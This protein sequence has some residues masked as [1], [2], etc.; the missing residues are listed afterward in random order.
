[1]KAKTCMMDLH[2]MNTKN[3]RRKL[4]NKKLTVNNVYIHAYASTDIFFCSDFSQTHLA[5]V[6]IFKT[7][8]T[9]YSCKQL[10]VSIVIS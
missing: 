3:Q 2:S 7:Q 9:N 4:M 8:I 1:M 5:T 6:I 10:L